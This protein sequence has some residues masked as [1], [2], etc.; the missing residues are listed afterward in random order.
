MILISVSFKFKI[1]LIYCTVTV[2]PSNRIRDIKNASQ[3]NA[4]NL[5]QLILKKK[6]I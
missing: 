2:T 5:L 1:V 4:L 6:N 3:I